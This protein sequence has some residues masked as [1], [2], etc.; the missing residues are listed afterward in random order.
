MPGDINRDFLVFL[1][2]DHGYGL[3]MMVMLY[4]PL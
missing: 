3:V 4:P 1:D 2:I